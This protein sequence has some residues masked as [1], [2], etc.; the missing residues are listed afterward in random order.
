MGDVTWLTGTVTDAR[1][2]PELGPLVELSVT[3]TNQRGSENVR[4][5]ATILVA[6]RK[7]GPVKLPRA[8]GPTPYRRV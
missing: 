4:A 8:P 6:S 2:D 1:V 7:H 5:T 3:G